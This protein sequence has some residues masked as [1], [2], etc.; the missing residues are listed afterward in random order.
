MLRNINAAINSAQ[1]SLRLVRCSTQSQKLLLQPHISPFLKQSVAI[2]SSPSMSLF[3]TPLRFKATR[4]SKRSK[5]SDE[6]V[7]NHTDDIPIPD[8]SSIVGAF[9]PEKTL[10]FDREGRI[11][12]YHHDKAAN[13]LHNFLR[14]I[15]VFFVLQTNLLVMEVIEPCK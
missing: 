15:T 8:T 6:P 14:S 5:R 13:Y 7:Y 10:I 1:A 3:Q 12:V 2:C 11:K 9:K 4:T